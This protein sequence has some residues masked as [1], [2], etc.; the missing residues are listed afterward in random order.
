MAT[1]RLH[2]L[3]VVVLAV[4]SVRGVAPAQAKTQVEPGLWVEVL[5]PR[6]IAV[7]AE[8]LPGESWAAM[9]RRLTGRDDVGRR[10]ALDWSEL[11]P[12]LQREAIAVLLPRDRCGA[13]VWEHWPSPRMPADGSFEELASWFAGDAAS[14]ASLERELRSGAGVGDGPLRIPCELIDPEL[15][16]ARA[17]CGLVPAT[18]IAGGDL[19][20]AAPVPRPSQWVAAEPDSRRTA[21]SVRPPP[22]ERVP[23]SGARD[24][25][26]ASAPLPVGARPTV[27]P[28]PG[29]RSTLG[30]ALTYGADDDGEYAVYRL[31]E[32]EAIYSSV[33][34]R[35]TGRLH[36][37]EVNELVPVIAKRSGVKSVR[38]LPVGFAVRVPLEFLAPE[39]LP[40]GHDRRLA[41]E[42]QRREVAGY[43]HQAVVA[44]LEGVVVVLDSGH[45]GRDRGASS[46]GVWESDYVYDIMCRIK[47]RLEQTTRAK[48]IPITRNAE[49][50]Y[51]T[52]DTRKLRPVTNTSVQTRPPYRL[53]D[54]RVGVNL[55]WY[56][57]NSLY[58]RHR[59][60]GGSPSRM[61]FTSVHADSL[62]PSVRGAMVYVPAAE[63]T[64]GR[65]GRK[66]KPYSRYREARER[67]IVS[68][69]SKER[70][71]AEGYSRELATRVLTAFAARELPIHAQKPIRGSVLRNRREW[72]PAVLRA[73]RIP[74][75]I[76]LEVCNL[77]NLEDRRLLTTVGFRE[78]VARA[79]VDALLDYYG[80][81]RLIAAR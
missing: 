75:R 76:L 14:A 59:D 2:A 20:R 74:S 68:H 49:I 9:A 79:Y 70:K 54:A 81:E 13:G 80:S 28:A 39:Y 48:V 17:C 22:V 46:N 72:L 64:R 1:R 4:A 36:A 3:V 47:R 34:I 78:S 65:H 30:S 52:R 44:A 31:R 40:D 32:G 41:W 69:S 57:A 37:R 19:L 53:T 16:R 42:R 66:G 15:A 67:P 24:L 8:P 25:L 26:V 71:R 21:V 29:G 33:I 45:G 6:G 27:A 10:V 61:V 7:E 73:N 11:R 56:L 51:Q 5:L 50:G 60:D 18:P 35:F 77:N 43:R 63:H 23:P 12:S 38:N 62:H 55:R 58:G